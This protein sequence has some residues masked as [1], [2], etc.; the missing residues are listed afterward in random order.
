MV[1]SL[2]RICS[3]APKARDPFREQR[4]ALLLAVLL[5]SVPLAAQDPGMRQ[6]ANTTG[7]LGRQTLFTIEGR[8]VA[9]NE[10]AS[11]S[12]VHVT[13]TDFRGSTRGSYETRTG[14]A[15]SFTNLSTGR[16]TLVFSHPDFVEQTQTVEILVMSPQALIVTL[17][18]KTR[19]VTSSAQLS[20]PAW[21]LQIPA[22]AQ[23]EYDKGLEAL[24]HEDV[25]VSIAHLRTAVQ[26]YPRFAAAYGALGTAYNS[27]GDLKAAADA[28]QKALEIDDSLFTTHLGLG[29]LYLAQQRYKE[30]E[31]YLL[32]AGTL[33]PEDWRAQYQLGDL[34]W[35][36]ADWPAS[37]EKLRR[38]IKLHGK[39]PRMYLLLINV[40]AGQEKYTETLAAMENFLKLFPDDRFAPQVA[41]KRDLLREEL[42]HQFASRK[43][44]PK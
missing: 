10:G 36:T 33:K 35:R 20:V 19:G 12:G 4:R 28:F 27:A 26:L 25:E 32:R 3:N 24:E 40:L 44:K 23:K 39:L 43:E 18:R 31:K 30:A 15:F 6:P 2:P 21:G 42:A 29:S 8:V 5:F 7:P 37:E 17:S 9:E 34:Y 16:Y 11:L 22:R 13:V 41:Q 38:A 14:G 1:F